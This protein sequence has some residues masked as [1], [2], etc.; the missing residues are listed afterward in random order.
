MQSQHELHLRVI[1]EDVHEALLGRTRV[2]KDVRD[3][4]GNQL[5]EQ[6]AFARQSR[7]AGERI[8]FACRPGVAHMVRT[9][10]S[11]GGYGQMLWA[12][13]VVLLLLWIGG[14]TLNMAGSLIHLI[15]VLAIIVAIY[16]LLVSRGRTI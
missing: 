15:L 8:N 2:A 12:L 9:P 1:L 14:F 4:V 11:K 13:V 5:L 3:T 16:N 6:S 7:H 10:L